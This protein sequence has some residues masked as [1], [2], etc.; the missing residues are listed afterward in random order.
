MD[1][2][3]FTF[4]NSNN[5]DI[6]NNPLFSPNSDE[7]YHY[8]R[9]TDELFDDIFKFNSFEKNNDENLILGF[10]FGNLPN[11]SIE[12]PNLNIP[13]EG[14]S[15]TTA[16]RMPANHEI[17]VK[18]TP[19]IFKIEKLK[20]KFIGRRNRD[21]VYLYEAEHTKF[22]KKDVLTKIKKA[23]YN[24]F[25]ELTNKNIKDSKDEEIKKREIELKK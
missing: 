11:L 25:L 6:N 9:Q 4:K 10:E 12:P 21:I 2:N 3:P 17:R 24:N 15:T 20:K 14:M 5:Y 16:T 23:A 18:T 1:S 19:P 13:N 7:S 8:F 22:E